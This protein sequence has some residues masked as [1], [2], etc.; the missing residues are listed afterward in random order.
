MMKGCAHDGI[1]HRGVCPCCGFTN[2]DGEFVAICKKCG[3]ECGKLCGLFVPHLCPD[4][5]RGELENDRKSGNI[6]TLCHS[7]RSACCC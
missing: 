7:P 1:L 3:D 2:I 4:C 5:Y 6:C